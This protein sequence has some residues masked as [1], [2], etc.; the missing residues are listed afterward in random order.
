MSG[1]ACLVLGIVLAA[2]SARADGA[3]ANRF[4]LELGGVRYGLASVSTTTSAPGPQHLLV[5]TQDVAPPLV[6]LVSTFAQGKPVKKD[7]RLASGAVVRKAND[8]RL[9]SVKLP[10]MGSGGAADIELAFVASALT[11]QPLLSA[12][13]SPPLPT[14]ARITGFRIDVSGLH[15]I[16][17]PK[18]DA[19]T[20]IQKADGNVTTG[21]I[22]FEAG[23]GGAL[24]FTSWH[25]AKTPRTVRIEYVGSDGKAILEIQLDRCT[26][27]SVTPRGANGTTR[28]ALTCANVHAT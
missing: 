18:L 16:E 2:S 7:L 14:A 6:G 25:K 4:A 26:T 28:I 27:V 1:R 15:A 8:A 24:P 10:A 20:L 22:A 11:T 17:A 12:K 9:A 13:E 19:I 21:D 3:N 23:A 5:T